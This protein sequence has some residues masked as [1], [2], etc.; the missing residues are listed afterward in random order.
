MENQLTR[1]RQLIGVYTLLLAIAKSYEPRHGSSIISV[2]NTSAWNLK[3]SNGI[4]M[5]VEYDGKASEKGSAS[6]GYWSN[7]RPA[8]IL[9]TEANIWLHCIKKIDGLKCY[10]ITPKRLLSLC[11]ETGTLTEI[12]KSIWGEH[13]RSKLIPLLQ[14]SKIAESEFL[15]SNELIRFSIDLL[16]GNPERSTTK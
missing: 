4:T 11:L 6:I 5:K 7:E 13:V 16:E 3:F 12:V 9:L 1:E 2:I 10:E 8:G 14:I 15:L